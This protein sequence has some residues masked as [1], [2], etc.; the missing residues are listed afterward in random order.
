LVKNTTAEGARVG[1]DQAIAHRLLMRDW[2]DVT[3]VGLSFFEGKVLAAIDRFWTEI[4]TWVRKWKW[5]WGF[6]EQSMLRHFRDSRTDCQ[7]HV[8]RIHGSHNSGLTIDVSVPKEGIM[9]SDKLIKLNCFVLFY[10]V[11]QSLDCVQFLGRED[12][13]ACFLCIVAVLSV[14]NSLAMRSLS[15]NARMPGP[16]DIRK[17]VLNL[18]RGWNWCGEERKMRVFLFEISV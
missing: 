6:D 15:L 12:F 11:M 7:T 16:G 13:L 5:Q 1:W 17:R 3:K 2:K 10:F 4:S 18:L 9:L 14:V 8:I